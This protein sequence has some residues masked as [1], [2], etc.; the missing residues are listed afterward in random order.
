M[1][2]QRLQLSRK[3]GFRLQEASR[4]LN[5]LPAV[6]VSR[7]SRWGNPYRMGVDGDRTECVALFQLHWGMFEKLNHRDI[8]RHL[9]GHNLACWCPLD[10]P[11]HAEILLKLAND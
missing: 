8:V 5:G 2:P 3:K 10:Q 4:A 9:R 6:V 7:P 1:T 11:C